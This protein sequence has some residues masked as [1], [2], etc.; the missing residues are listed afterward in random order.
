MSRRRR[1]C[2]CHVQFESVG[3]KFFWQDDSLFFKS[4]HNVEQIR[5][6]IRASIISL[7]LDNM[8]SV[9]DIAIGLWYDNLNREYYLT[10]MSLDGEESF[11][12]DRSTADGMTA[13]NLEG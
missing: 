8:H 2:Q 1:S 3:D 13:G 10:Y 6:D 9:I 12:D 5:T 4:A 11:F 7:I